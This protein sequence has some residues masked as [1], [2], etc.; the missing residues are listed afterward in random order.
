MAEVE[1]EEHR[2]GGSDDVF[3]LRV[4]SDAHQSQVS[5]ANGETNARVDFELFDGMSE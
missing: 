4:V 5:T 1:Q 2:C 3:N